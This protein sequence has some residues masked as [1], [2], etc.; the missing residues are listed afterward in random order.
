MEDKVQLVNEAACIVVGGGNTFHLV[1]ELHRYGLM[2]AIAEAAKKGTAYIGWS[3]GS[4]IAAPTLCT[5]NDMPIVQPASFNTLNLVP[6]QIKQNVIHTENAFYF[7]L[8]YSLYM[9][10]I[11]TPYFPILYYTLLPSQCQG[12][13]ERMA[14]FQIKSIA[15]SRFFAIFISQF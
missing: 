7:N 15:F 5:T 13:Q 11:I 10:K 4:N 14:N 6:F 12:N 8:L 3:A 2:D 9:G 1:A